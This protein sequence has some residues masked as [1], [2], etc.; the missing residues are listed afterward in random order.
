[1]EDPAKVIRRRL[2]R[3]AAGSG[4]DDLRDP[5]DLSDEPGRVDGSTSRQRRSSGD[6]REQMLDVVLTGLAHI[7]KAP[8]AFVNGSIDAYVKLEQARKDVLDDLALA[9]VN[10][11]LFGG[12]VSCYR[13]SGTSGIQAWADCIGITVWYTEGAPAG[14]GAARSQER[15]VLL[16]L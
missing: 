9:E 5:N 1:M 12:R 13:F 3:A 2:Q 15:A 8:G 11:A 16:G 7:F 14:G 10:S 6:R 4:G